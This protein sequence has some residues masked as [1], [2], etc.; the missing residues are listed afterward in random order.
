MIN[1]LKKRSGQQQILSIVDLQRDDLLLDKI[2]ELTLK[3]INKDE[4]T[5]K[6][7]MVKS[8]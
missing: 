5:V 1:K 8:S 4:S 2:D 7:L 3:V 6:N